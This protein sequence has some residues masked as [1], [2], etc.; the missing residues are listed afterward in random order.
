M[1]NATERG[2]LAHVIAVV[3]RKGGVGKTT[4]AT[5]LAGELAADGQPV[6]LVDLDPQGNAG[7]DLGYVYAD[8]TEMNSAGEAV[9]DDEGASLVRAVAEGAPLNPM[10]VRDNLDV[11][12]G[13]DHTQELSDWLFLTAHTQGPQAVQDSLARALL[14]IASRYAAVIL[15]CP[16]GTG[17]LQTAAL[18]TARWILVPAGADD[19][20]ATGLEALIASV[21]LARETNPTLDFLGLALF[22]FPV[23]ATRSVQAS[24]DGY[25]EIFTQYGVTAPVFGAFIRQS[26]T[27]AALARSRGQLVRELAADAAAE[28]AW[29]ER[30]GRKAR[31]AK[32]AVVVDDGQLP[33]L[34]SHNL[35]ADWHSLAIEVVTRLAQAQQPTRRQRKS[36]VA[37]G[38]K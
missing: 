27:T 33:R 20:S 28:P 14:P 32:K 5:H 11:I 30:F 13:G 4:T 35:A 10:R 3:L 34:S 22:G 8:G 16:P 38:A 6:L 7:S 1:L 37:G 15:D 26:A 17:P 29:W 2:Q 31:Q 9:V 18:Q 25:A 36:A 23:S 19:A 21:K 24:R 12:A